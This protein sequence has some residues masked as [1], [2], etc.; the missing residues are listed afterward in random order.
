MVSLFIYEVT[1][2][3]GEL[4]AVGDSMLVVLMLTATTMIDL[5]AIQIRGAHRLLLWSLLITLAL[6]SAWFML[7]NALSLVLHYPADQFNREILRLMSL[8]VLAGAVVVAVSIQ[9]YITLTRVGH[10]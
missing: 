5:S 8:W 10:K 9:M 7:A 1:H 6:A 3:K 2:G 4:F